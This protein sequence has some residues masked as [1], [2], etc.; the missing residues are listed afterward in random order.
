MHEASYIVPFD[1]LNADDSR[2]LIYRSASALM[3]G[4]Q[5]LIANCANLASLVYHSMPNI[6]WCGWY[7]LQYNDLVLGP[8]AGKPACTR[9][10][11]GRGVCGTAAKERRTIVVDD[12]TAFEGHIACDPDTRS[13]LVVP[14][15]AGNSFLGVFD[16]DSA[17]P[18]RFT[19]S[20]VA[21]IESLCRLLLASS[22]Y[23]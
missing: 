23:D 11:M 10:R 6:S 9:I 19:Q 15:A 1:P 2:E 4:E 3:Q 7:L 18:S 13:E 21:F 12:V 16:L 22:R 17:V 5:D 14:L 20:D 8:F